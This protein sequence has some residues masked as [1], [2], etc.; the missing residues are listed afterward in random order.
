MLAATLAFPLLLFPALV[1]EDKAPKAEARPGLGATAGEDG[2]EPLFDGE[3]LAGW[4]GREGFWQV[5]DGALVGRTSEA[6]PAP[7]NTFLVSDGEYGDFDLRFQYRVK[8]YNSGVQSRSEVFDADGYR[9]KGPQADIDAAPNYTGMYYDEGAGGLGIVARRGQI[10]EIAADGA[11]KVVGSCGDEAALQEKFVKTWD[12][13]GGGGWNEMRVVADG[14]V[15]RHYLNGRLFSEG[16]GPSPGPPEGRR[17]G[18]PAAPRPADGA[19]RQKRAAEGVGARRRGPGELRPGGEPAE[20]RG[21]GR[22]GR[23]GRRGGP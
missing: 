14:P 15:T 12:G 21:R 16:D 11:V 6:N 9:V 19:A 5:E 1:Q 18:V 22:R 2:F 3:S 10:A 4:S 20:R 23:R 17:A 8:D 13:A 7:F